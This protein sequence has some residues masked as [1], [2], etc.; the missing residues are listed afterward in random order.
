MHNNLQRA[1]EAGVI[2]EV[3][4]AGWLADLEQRDG[5][6]RFFAAMVGFGVVGRKV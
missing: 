3:E 2:T 4:A 5:E 6:G 1:Q